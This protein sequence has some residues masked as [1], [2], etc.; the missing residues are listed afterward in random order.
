MALDFGRSLINFSR[1]ALECKS[2]YIYYYY[3]NLLSLIRVDFYQQ[4]GKGRREVH[5]MS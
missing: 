2:Y 3:T 1:V 4:R 5:R